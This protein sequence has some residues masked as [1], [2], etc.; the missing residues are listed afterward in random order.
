MSKLGHPWRAVALL[1]LAIHG[2]T[3]LLRLGA[4]WPYPRL[5]DFGA[6]Y[7]AAAAMR[8][9][10]PPYFPSQGFLDAL[11]ASSGMPFR[12]PPIF[13]PPPW[14]LLLQPFALLPFPLAA[15]IWLLLQLAILSWCGRRLADLADVAGIGRWVALAVT[16][17]FGPGF[18]DLTLGQ[19][20]TLLLLTALVVGRS[21]AASRNPAPFSGAAGQALAVAVKLY[22]AFWMGALVLRRRWRILALALLLTG[23]IFLAAGLSQPETSR[24]YWLDYLPARVT[25]ATEQVNVDDQAWMAWWDRLTLPQSFAVPGLGSSER[26][27]IRWNPAWNLN[28]RRVRAAGYLLLAAMAGATVWVLWR[29]RPGADEPAFYLWVLLGLLA[30]P[31]T[32]RYNHAL[33][34]PAMAWLWGEGEQG[35]RVAVTGY[36]LAGLA[37]LTHLWVLVLPWPWAPLATGFGV[38]AV[39]ALMAGMARALPRLAPGGAA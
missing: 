10:L 25:A 18:L 12:P 38:L 39:L 30:F 2:G 37:R 7:A 28:R 26:H 13:N 29:A 11:R 16:V 15:W 14:P 32:E 27:P 33:L 1:A 9:G 19:T 17:T 8:Q 6:F 21:L 35:R 31:H 22:P 4:F 3:A 24:R 5:V 34:L 23:A 20:S 36:L